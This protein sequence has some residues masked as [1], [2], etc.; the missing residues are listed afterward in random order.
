MKQVLIFHSGET[1]CS[2]KPSY[3]GSMC[4]FVASRKFGREYVCRLFNDARLTDT[5]GWLQ[6]L[7]VCLSEFR[8]ASDNDQLVARL[9]AL[10]RNEHDDL[11]IGDE[12]AD[13]I[14]ELEDLTRSKT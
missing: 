2:E 8:G 6:R 9:R 3:P 5:D 7:P 14:T 4:P 13:R 1:T 11:S 10:A 12:A